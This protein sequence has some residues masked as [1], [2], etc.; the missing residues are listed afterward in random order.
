MRFVLR[1]LVTLSIGTPTAYGITPGYQP[2]FVDFATLESSGGCAQVVQAATD[3]A[4]VASWGQEQL[5]QL[6]ACSRAGVIPDGFMNGTVILAPNGG[7]DQFVKFATSLGFPIDKASLTTFAQSLWKGKM[8]YRADKALLNK[9]GPDVKPIL[10]HDLKDQMRFPAKVFCGQSLLDAR[11]ESIVIDYAFSDQVKVQ[12]QSPY[13]DDIDWIA[14]GRVASGRRGLNIRDEIRMVRPGFYLGRAYIDRVFV[15]NFT[16]STDTPPSGQ[17][18][19]WAG[20]AKES[21]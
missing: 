15:L 16:L 6:Y 5:D 14:A 7:F 4:T 8:F 10:G 9:M 19:C 1:L 18:V 17:D 13:V 20:A 12:G 3:A 21:T 11:R 2:P